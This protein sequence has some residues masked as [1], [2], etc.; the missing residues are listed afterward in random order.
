MSAVFYR[1]W[2]RRHLECLSNGYNSCIASLIDWFPGQILGTG[3]G[4]QPLECLET[5]V[6][7]LIFDLWNAGKPWSIGSKLFF[8]KFL[9]IL[10]LFWQKVLKI[11]LFFLEKRKLIFFKNFQCFQGILAKSL[12]NLTF[13][14]QFFKKFPKNHQ[15]FSKPNPTW[16]NLT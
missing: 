14:G 1:M 4:C 10:A 9:I 13:F 8:S 5:L 6:N 11:G 2:H 12:E 15:F 3:T 7:G 16:P